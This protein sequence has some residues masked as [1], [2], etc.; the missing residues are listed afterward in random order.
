MEDA[1]GFWNFTRLT[2]T[3]FEELLLMVGGKISKEDTKFRET[4]TAS[5]RLAVTLRFLASV[6]SF[7]SLVYT[8]R[9]L[10]VWIQAISKIVPEVC[11]VIISSLK[12]QIKV[13]I[14]RSGA[15]QVLSRL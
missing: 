12:Q 6:D 4:I 8:F 5:L 13:C 7:M 14:K 10:P 3:D 9:I 2:P 11:E 1:M 15:G